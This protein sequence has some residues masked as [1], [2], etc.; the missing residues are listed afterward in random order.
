MRKGKAVCAGWTDPGVHL[1]HRATAVAWFLYESCTCSG[2]C[3]VCYGKLGRSLPSGVLSVACLEHE[4][5][6]H[7]FITSKR[8]VSAHREDEN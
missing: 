5:E 3:P 8:E 4:I 7:A 2:V 1:W 6:Q